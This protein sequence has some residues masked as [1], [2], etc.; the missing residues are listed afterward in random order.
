MMRLSQDSIAD[1]ICRLNPVGN[2]GGNW[3]PVKSVLAI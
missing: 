3:T 1:K 2:T